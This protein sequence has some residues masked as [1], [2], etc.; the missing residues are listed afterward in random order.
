MKHQKYL[1]Y[2]DFAS[3]ASQDNEYT[4]SYNCD[5]GEK[6]CIEKCPEQNFNLEDALMNN[7]RMDKIRN[8]MI[9]KSDFDKSRIVDF[10]SARAAVANRECVGTYVATS[11]CEY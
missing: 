3:C 10:E 6:V 2:F 1:Y 8:D 4:I 11:S 5:G 9:C 7:G